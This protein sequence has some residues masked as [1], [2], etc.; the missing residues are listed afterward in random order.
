MDIKPWTVL[1]SIRDKSYRVFSLRTDHVRSPRTGE[2]YDFFVLESPPWV[3]IIP[4]T[5]DNQVVMVRQYRHGTREITLEIPG[6]LVEDKDT[7][8][9]AA[10]RELREETGYTTESM[11]SLG[12][13]YPNPAIQSNICHTFLARNVHPTGIQEQDEK[14]D[15]DVVLFPLSDIPRLIREGAISHALVIVAF[16]KLWLMER[17]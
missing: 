7:P 4:L 8:E 6:G 5:P 1:S 14:E 3:N 17:T 11:T 2:A 9:E 13:I 15:I 10:H 12:F 16:Q